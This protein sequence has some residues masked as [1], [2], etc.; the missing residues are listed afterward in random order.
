VFRPSTGTWFIIDSATGA[1]RSRQ[2]GEA[3]DIP[4]PGDY[5]GDGKADLAVWRPSTGT[6]WIVDS[7]TGADRAVQWGRFG[8]VPV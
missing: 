4:V 6:W 1:H 8:D 3:S 5:D 2:W 7:A